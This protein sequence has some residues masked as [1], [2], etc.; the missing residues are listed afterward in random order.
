MNAPKQIPFMS[1]ERMVSRHKNEISNNVMRVYS[2]GQML[3][4]K[5]IDDLENNLTRLCD[6]KF[7]VTVNSCTDAIYFALHAAGIRPGD[8]VLITSFS[9]IASVSPILR[10]GAVPVFVDLS[11]DCFMMTLGD[12]E[13]KITPRTKAIIVVH[14]FGQML[15]L[16]AIEKMAKDH[17]LTVIEDAAQSIGSYQNKR[18]AGNL[19]L[20]SCLSFDPTKIIGAFG[21]GGAVLTDDLTVYKTLKKLHYHGKNYKTGNFEIIGYNS[22]ISSSQAALLNFQLDH[23]K[24]WISRRNEIASMYSEKLKHLCQI[25]TPKILSGNIHTFHKYVIKTER[26]HELIQFLKNKGIETKIHYEKLLFEYKLFNNYKFFAE[27]IKTAHHVKDSVLS[28]PIYPELND[29]E[30]KY[31][32]LKISE[33][34]S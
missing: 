32:S 31:I 18:P 7:A 3:H 11:E 13:K 26:R 10:I 28:L 9:F 33:F 15:P 22:R 21:T 27:N 1:I 34:F 8:E 24:K 4:D 29:T 23:L 14:L 2:S 12:I 6:R 5:C 20:A 17:G 25:Q 30:V 16:D 19:G